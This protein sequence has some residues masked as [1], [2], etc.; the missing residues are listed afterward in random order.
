MHAQ[1]RDNI[2]T[3]RLGLGC[4]DG[5]SR[6]TFRP[7]RIWVRIC[8][9][10]DRAA[11]PMRPRTRWE[12]AM[13]FPRSRWMCALRS[14]TAVP[15]DAYRGAGKPEANYLLERLIDLAARR[16]G[17]D[18]AESRRRNMIDTFPYTKALGSVVDCGRFA[19]AIDDAETLGD[20]SGFAG[21]RCGNPEQHWQNLRGLNGTLLPLAHRRQWQMRRMRALT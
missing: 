20:R 10:G 16:H 18:P 6:W 12:A 1:G 8:R 4:E 3:A 7:W 19:A 14:L 13:S 17:F 9:A 11:R 21:R 5:F 15:I 2:T